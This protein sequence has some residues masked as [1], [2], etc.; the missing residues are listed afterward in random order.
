MEISM[1]TANQL[2]LE[3]LDSLKAGDLRT[4]P[5]WERAHEICQAHEGEA[6]FDWIHALC[7]RIEGDDGNAGYWYRSAGR[8]RNRGTIAEEWAAI[9]DA[10]AG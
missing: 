1:S 3:A 4:G 6:D 10:L 7:H 8:A 9:R 5:E 2:L